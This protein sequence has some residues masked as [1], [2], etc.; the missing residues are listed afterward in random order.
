MKTEPKLFPFVRP[1]YQNPLLIE[2]A[3][4][5]RIFGADGRE[6]LDAYAGVASVSVG[7]ANPRVNARVIEQIGRVHHTTMIYRTHPLETYLAALQPVLGDRLSRHFFVNSGSEAIDFACQTSRARRGRPLIISFSEGF[8][9]GSYLA[10]SV[11]GLPAWQPA[12]GG[13]RDVY[14][15]PIDSCRTCEESRFDPRAKR[16]SPLNLDCSARC[17][18]SLEKLLRIRS[19][20]AAAV[21]VEPIL[22]V[23]GILTP[24][25]GFFR[26]LTALCDTADLDLICDEVQTGFGRCGGS[27]FAFQQVGLEPDLLCLAK[28]IANGFPLGLVSGTEDV[29]QGVA[30]K[31]HF[32]TFG[33]NPVSCAAADETLKIILEDHLPDRAAAVGEHFMA[34]LSESLCDIDG[35]VEIRG[36]GLMIGLELADS[37]AAVRV[38]ENAYRRGLL[39]GLGGRRRNTIRIEPPLIFTMA[40]ADHALDLLTSAVR[41]E[42]GRA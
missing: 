1:Y 10:K 19:R 12:F 24:P 14:F 7:H 23:G 18:E 6:Y 28:G 15:H 36:L 16:F 21:L 3:E 41:E 4:G 20:E 40:D 8:H 34:G 5:C 13:D 31:L 38:H 26:R 35:V 2:R 37:S 17:L 29:V 33:G 27:L 42:T 32:S 9:G 25:K 39:L 22:G 30:E 11:T